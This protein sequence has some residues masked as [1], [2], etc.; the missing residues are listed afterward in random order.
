MRVSAVMSSPVHRISPEQSIFDAAK[1][2]AS[3]DIGALPVIDDDELVGIVT[4]RDIIVR[5]VAN[6]IDLDEGVTSI[7]SRDVQTC[8]PNDDLG[9]VLDQMADLQLRR[10]PVSGD[11]GSVV[12]ILTI[13]D[14]ARA[15][16]GEDEV[17]EALSEICTPEAE[18][19]QGIA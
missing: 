15:E 14:V 18:F 2:M 10:L 11:D 7:M 5:A 4:D 1:L 19:A 9:E 6:G 12:G 17:G 8:R 3:D 13:G 16:P